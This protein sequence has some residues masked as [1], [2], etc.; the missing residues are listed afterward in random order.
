MD[1][2]CPHC[3]QSFVVAGRPETGGE[4][5]VRCPGC[6]QPARIQLGAPPEAL[7]QRDRKETVFEGP[8]GR[9]D[10][11]RI[12]QQDVLGDDATATTTAQVESDGFDDGLDGDTDPEAPTEAEAKLVADETLDA[13]AG[14]LAM[15]VD[16]PTRKFDAVDGPSIRL[17][18]DL[19][20][21]AARRR[22]L[23]TRRELPTVAPPAP[24]T[25]VSAM[26]TSDSVP[27]VPWV[28]LGIG[29]VLVLVLV[30]VGAWLAIRVDA[31]L[32]EP[33]TATSGPLQPLVAAG[34][35]AENVKESESEPA[36]AA[37]AEV[38]V[39]ASEG[40]TAPEEPVAA[41]P[42]EPAQVK[43]AA[44]EPEVEAEPEAERAPEPEPTAAPEPTETA[45]ARRPRATHQ[46][47]GTSADRD[48]PFLALRDAPGS[49][50]RMLAEMPDGTGLRLL[51][52]RG[53][54]SRVEVV[55]GPFAG[56]IGWAHK[57]WMTKK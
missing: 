5:K 10:V 44:A 21:P 47:A 31:G 16:P 32:Q 8:Q 14:A 19:T 56:Q 40:A 39:P 34:P 28:G 12:G 33:T 51:S 13:P 2:T 1:V 42:E 52:Q 4:R 49:D 29:A 50:A 9:D 38:A 6:G 18:P 24:D 20:D 30:A 7:T 3:H 11:T 53:R 36:A 26:P 41:A 15:P 54:W 37:P 43:M 48:A 27:S 25:E 22:A 23:E 45:P 46:V 35:A 57:R 55:D 17:R